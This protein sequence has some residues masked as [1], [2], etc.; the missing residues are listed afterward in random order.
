MTPKRCPWSR[1]KARRPDMDRA[2]WLLHWLGFTSWVRRT[3]RSLRTVKG[4][5]ATAWWLLFGL[6]FLVSCFG[7]SRMGDASGAL[8]AVDAK[9][10]I[11]QVERYGG[12]VLLALCLLNVVTTTGKGSPI[13]FLS[14]EVEFLVAGPFTRRGLLTHKLVQIVLVFAILSAFCLF[15]PALGSVFR[16]PSGPW[17]GRYVGIFLL[18]M[19]LNLVGMNLASVAILVGTSVYQRWRKVTL[20]VIVVAATVATLYVGW[21]RPEQHWQETLT[22]LEQSPVGH[23][24]LEVPRCFVRATLVQHYWPDFVLWG[25]TC[26]AIDAALVVLFFKLDAVNI[27]AAAVAGE[28]VYAQMQQIRRG[29]RLTIGRERSG[30]AGRSLPVLPW[31]GGVGPV[32]WRQL[33]ALV[34][35]KM[36]LV[37]LVLV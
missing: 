8:D 10:S 16:L 27:E 18:W 15:F 7:L 36:S 12:L 2:L 17:F 3:L 20:S 13:V 6:F 23:A 9:I 34:R 30:K 1:Q 24:L 25:G 32:A 5:L 33:Q 37:L 14:P 11:E 4:I 29:E 28:R 21:G 35:R 26:F 22:Q 19:F 31:W